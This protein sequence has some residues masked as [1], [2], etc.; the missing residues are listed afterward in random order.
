MEYID[1]A[2]AKGR[3]VESTLELFAQM[4]LTFPTYSK[5]SRKLFFINEEWQVRMVLVKSA[6]V[7]TYVER[8]AVDLGIVGKD[9]LLE[10][11]AQIY[12]LVDLGFGVCKMVVA[13]KDTAYQRKPKPIVATK[14]PKIAQAYFREKD[15]PIETITLHGSVELA[16]L[17]G[18]SDCIVD[19]VETG[20]TLRENGLCITE[21]I[22]SLSARLVV[23]R[24]SFK[25]K[26]HRL[27]SLINRIQAEVDR[28]EAAR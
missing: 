1:M 6:D 14:Y 17:A 19:I 18:L 20:T 16:P 12:E 5:D 13:S 4:G 27:S 11:G 15:R 2:V 26:Y 22:A 21:E 10:S 23:N 8:G 9:M 3:L 24:A 28:R 25:T 7:P